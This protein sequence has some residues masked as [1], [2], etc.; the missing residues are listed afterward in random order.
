MS[1]GNQ[2]V[3][4]CETLPPLRVTRAG[5]DY[6]CGPTGL[7]TGQQLGVSY[8]ES[9]IGPNSIEVLASMVVGCTEGS[10]ACQVPLEGV[11]HL[12]AEVPRW[13]GYR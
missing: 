4:E 2:A 8:G 11:R 1:P 5:I 3:P 10:G 13:S 7:P 12:R 9:S 6:K